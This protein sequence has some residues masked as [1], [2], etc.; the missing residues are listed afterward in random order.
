VG[1]EEEGGIGERGAE[2]GKSRKGWRG[3]ERRR[4]ERERGGGKE[5]QGG[6]GCSA[7]GERG[8]GCGGLGVEIEEMRIVLCPKFKRDTRSK[9]T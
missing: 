9:K 8:N 1:D 7:G 6:G 4:R 3:R 2:E 5:G